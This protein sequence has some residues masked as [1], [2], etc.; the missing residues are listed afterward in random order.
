MDDNYCCERFNIHCLNQWHLNI[1]QSLDKCPSGCRIMSRFY[2][3]YRFF[4]SLFHVQPMIHEK[5][6]IRCRCFV[7]L[8]MLYLLI[9][10]SNNIGCFYLLGQFLFS[11]HV[12]CLSVWF[13]E[14]V[15][16]YPWCFSWRDF[17]WLLR[18]V[19]HFHSWGV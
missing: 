5:L 3:L 16:I 6:Y 15:S 10:K 19:C 7:N 4:F 1:F 8:D 11:V 12:I 14:S 9:L 17:D 2:N 13:A 18:N